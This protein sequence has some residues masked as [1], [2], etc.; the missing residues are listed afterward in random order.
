M[1]EEEGRG[2]DKEKIMRD[3]WALSGKEKYER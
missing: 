2:K 1:I 3:N